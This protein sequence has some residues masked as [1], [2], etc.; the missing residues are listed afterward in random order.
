MLFRSAQVQKYGWGSG[1][2]DA[3]V[4]LEGSVRLAEM[5]VWERGWFK[6]GMQPVKGVFTEPYSEWLMYFYNEEEGDK[7]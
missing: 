1:K 3:G 4:C 2:A 7:S 5:Q 6:G